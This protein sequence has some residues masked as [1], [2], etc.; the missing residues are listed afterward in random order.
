MVDQKFHEKLFLF[1]KS[2]YFF[3]YYYQD[4]WDDILV[5]QRQGATYG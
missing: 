4:D 1:Q 5:T 2:V 3:N